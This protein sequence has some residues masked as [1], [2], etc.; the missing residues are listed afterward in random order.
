MTFEE[1][2]EKEK[3]EITLFQ[4]D[5]TDD[6]SEYMKKSIQESEQMSRDA[7]NSASSVI[8]Y[9]WTIYS[10]FATLLLGLQLY[11][12]LNLKD[13]AKKVAEAKEVIDQY[14]NQVEDLEEKIKL[15]ENKAITIDDLLASADDSDVIPVLKEK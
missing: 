1:L 10:T 5:Y 11:N 14:A 8:I 13:D 3:G 12:A 15:L 4:P 7:L 2:V 9:R 6:F